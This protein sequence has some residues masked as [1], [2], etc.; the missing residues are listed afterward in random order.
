MSDSSLVKGIVEQLEETAKGT[1]SQAA[2]VPA[3]LAKGAVEQIIGQQKPLTEEELKR[4]EEERQKE[5]VKVQKNLAMIKSTQTQIEKMPEEHLTAP[6]PAAIEK[7]PQD[8]PMVVKQKRPESK[9][10][11]KG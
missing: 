1:I 2:Q 4:K 5:I 3:D 6:P 9:D 11:G 7:K 10:L 8:L